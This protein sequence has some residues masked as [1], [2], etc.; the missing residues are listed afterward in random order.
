MNEFKEAVEKCEKQKS[1][2]EVKLD[3]IQS[4]SKKAR[5]KDKALFDDLKVQYR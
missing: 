1:N 2:T 3:R 4:D 5:F